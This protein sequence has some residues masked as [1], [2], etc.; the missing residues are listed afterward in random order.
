MELD[1]RNGREEAKSNGQ[2]AAFDAKR[3]ENGSTQPHCSPVTGAGA[4]GAL[5]GAWSRREH[6]GPVHGARLPGING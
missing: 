2:A 5:N 4:A 3:L 1:R 6:D